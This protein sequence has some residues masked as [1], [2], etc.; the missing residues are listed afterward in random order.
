MR[1]VQAFGAALLAG[2]SSYGPI[3]LMG[4]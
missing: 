1:Y 2:V 4:V 3:K